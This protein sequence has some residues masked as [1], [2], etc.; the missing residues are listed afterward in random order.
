MRYYVFIRDFNGHIIEWPVITDNPAEARHVFCE[1]VQ[2]EDLDGKRLAA[3]LAA[4]NLFVALHIFS[5]KPG[6]KNYWKDRINEI[7]LPEENALS[8]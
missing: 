3:V 1:T 5:R 8:A 2:R 6:D 7:V 4:D